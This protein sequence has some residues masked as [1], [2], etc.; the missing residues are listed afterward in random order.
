MTSAYLR[1]RKFP[2][3]VCCFGAGHIGNLQ[4]LSQLSLLL[5]GALLKR[6]VLPF[7]AVNL[8]QQLVYVV[9]LLVQLLGY[10]GHGVAAGVGHDDCECTV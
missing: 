6:K 2:P 5:G 4:R 3:C 10:V 8:L 1:N 7:Q 9:H